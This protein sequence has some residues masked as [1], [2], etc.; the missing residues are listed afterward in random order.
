MIGVGAVTRGVVLGGCDQRG[1][2]KGGGCDQ[3]GGDRGL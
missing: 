3:K 2:D 1:G